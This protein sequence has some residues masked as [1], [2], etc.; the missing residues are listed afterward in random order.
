M[1][2]MRWGSLLL[3]LC[4]GCGTVREKPI[5][6]PR[7]GPELT[8]D[9]VTIAPAE[10]VTA[11]LA[12]RPRRPVR[13]N[14]SPVGEADL[15]DWARSACLIRSDRE[16]RLAVSE[17]EYLQTHDFAAFAQYRSQRT[18][19]AEQRAEMRNYARSQGLTLD[20]PRLCQLLNCVRMQCMEDALHG[21]LRRI[22]DAVQAEMR[23]TK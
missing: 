2:L 10:P 3:L 1:N 9:A 12:P 16:L 23:R 21:K 4:A 8:P 20:D 13:E 11:F 7:S 14:L 6:L 19:L 18:R 5:R 15:R 22:I 17:L